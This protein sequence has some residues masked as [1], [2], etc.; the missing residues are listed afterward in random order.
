[1]HL[2]LEPAIPQYETIGCVEVREERPMDARERWRQTFL[3]A[4]ER[5][6]DADLATIGEVDFGVIAF[7]PKE[8]NL[9]CPGQE[10]VFPRVERDTK[11]AGSQPL[12]AIVNAG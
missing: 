12:A 8:T 11:I 4:L 9:S 2:E 7:G 6:L 5:L 1:M 3:P 10:H